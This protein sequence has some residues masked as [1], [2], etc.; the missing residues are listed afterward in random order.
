LGADMIGG[1]CG[2]GPEQIRSMG[3]VIC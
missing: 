2:V 1:C 3:K